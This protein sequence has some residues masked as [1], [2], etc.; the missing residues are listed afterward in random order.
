MQFSSPPLVLASRSPRRQEL[1]RQLGLRFDVMAADVIERRAPGQ[2]PAEYAIA[3]ALAKA[4]V[5]VSDA[6]VIGA[7]TDVVIDNDILGK[8][9]GAADAL[10]MLSR[11]SAREHQVFSAVALV[12]GTRSATRLSMTRVNFGP[13]SA[14]EAQTYWDS[15][16]PA[17]KAG[18]YAIQGL[19]A[20][21]V[22]EIHGSYSGV[23]G[24]PL[25]ETCELLMSFG[26]EPFTPHAS[27]LTP[28]AQ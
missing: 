25:F 28:H 21:F 11:L 7:D 8:P 26:I 4:R 6:V 16:E 9:R 13:I 27:H 17:D 12:H 15:G 2:S 19:G 3:T 18:A 23:V 10:A 1:L 20:R 5:V 24:L 14:Q 22:K